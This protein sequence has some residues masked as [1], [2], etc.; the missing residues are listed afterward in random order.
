MSRDSRNISGLCND[1]FRFSGLDIYREAEPDLSSEWIIVCVF[2][3]PSF[4]LFL[5]NLL[6]LARVRSHG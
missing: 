1:P 6:E 4:V 3:T 5:V 2:F